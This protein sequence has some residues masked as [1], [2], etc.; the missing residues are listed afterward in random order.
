LYGQILKD[1]STRIEIRREQAK[2]LIELGQIFQD[3]ANKFK[4]GNKDKKV[5]V[6]KHMED[7]Y[8]RAAVEADKGNKA[9]KT[10]IGKNDM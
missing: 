4:E 3:E 9:S 10:D 1:M 6:F 5:D 2:A 7:A 8:I